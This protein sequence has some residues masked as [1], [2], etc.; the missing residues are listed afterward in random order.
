MVTF[1]IALLQ[2]LWNIQFPGIVS[3]KGEQTS[4]DSTA[5]YAIAVLI[6]V[7]VGVSRSSGDRGILPRMAPRRTC[8]CHHPY[9]LYHLYQRLITS[10]SGLNSC[11]CLYLV[12]ILS[13]SKLR[14]WHDYPAPG[15]R[16]KYIAHFTEAAFLVD[17]AL[18]QLR[19][20]ILSL[21]LPFSP[22]LRNSSR[23][24]ISGV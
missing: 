3:V 9:H 19:S 2:V 11:C 22:A 13:H 6:A 24:R 18:L 23:P 14:S 17:Q 4:S 10:F 12:K 8:I 16:D 5:T 15:P 7:I 21:C 20:G 1:V